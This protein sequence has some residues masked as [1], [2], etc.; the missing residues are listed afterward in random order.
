MV[1]NQY[2]K[3]ARACVREHGLDPNQAATEFFRLG[4]EIGMTVHDARTL[5]DAAKSAP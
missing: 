5:R 3:H 1:M 4:V 2:R